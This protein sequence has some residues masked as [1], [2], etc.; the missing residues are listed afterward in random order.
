MGW[1]KCWCT[2]TKKDEC[3]HHK[4][5]EKIGD[6]EIRL[7]SPY[8]VYSKLLHIFNIFVSFEKL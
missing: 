5:L 2:C 3:T 4:N 6:A 1:I 8:D 7:F